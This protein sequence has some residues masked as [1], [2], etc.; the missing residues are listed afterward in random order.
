[1][2][3]GGMNR[4]RSTAPPIFSE[5]FP[6]RRVRAHPSFSSHTNFPRPLAARQSVDVRE[7]RVKRPAQI[8]P[9]MHFAPLN[10]PRINTSEKFPISRI[11]LIRNDFNPTRINTSGNKDL[12]SI[13]INT[14]GS[15][16][17]K[18]FR[19]NTSKNNGRGEGMSQGNA[20]NQKI[21]APRSR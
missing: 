1:M 16:D 8:Q 13:R 19:I 20:A 18:S 7:S 6:T 3:Y 10:S 15:K 14:S 9:F 11:L 21:R 12:K 5:V 2:I 4:K 17:L